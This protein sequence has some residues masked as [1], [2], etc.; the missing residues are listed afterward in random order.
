MFR[1]VCAGVCE[2]DKHRITTGATAAMLGNA[3]NKTHPKVKS[4]T[5]KRRTYV[6]TFVCVYERMPVNAS[7]SFKL[8]SWDWEDLGSEEPST[9]A[10]GNDGMAG[11]GARDSRLTRSTPHPNETGTSMTACK[12]IYVRTEMLTGPYISALA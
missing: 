5:A 8:R 6:S 3:G 9:T 4:A 2:A 12:C 11:M 1:F 10:G 7:L